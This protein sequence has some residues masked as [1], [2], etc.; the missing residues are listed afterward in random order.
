MS[1]TSTYSG[2]VTVE[3]GPDQA[4]ERLGAPVARILGPTAELTATRWPGGLARMPGEFPPDPIPEVWLTYPALGQ[5]VRVATLTCRS[6]LY[7]E[8]PELQAVTVGTFLAHDGLVR[9]W[10]EGTDFRALPGQLP[11]DP[12]FFTACH[13]YPARTVWVGPDLAV[14]I[15]HEAERVTVLCAPPQVMDTVVLTT[16]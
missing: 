13:A 16:D 8:D 15:L 7:Q 3:G 1:V 9:D 5:G 14:R 2:W 4:A 12:L 11:Q 6:D 10:P